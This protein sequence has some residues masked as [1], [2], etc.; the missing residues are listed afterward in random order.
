VKKGTQLVSAL[1]AEPRLFQKFGPKRAASP[2]SQFSDDQGE[3]SPMRSL[4]RSILGFFTLGMLTAG[5]GQTENPPAP[6]D[7]VAS[8]PGMT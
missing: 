2:F 6:A 4:L 1:V 3:V 7:V 5:C 8:V